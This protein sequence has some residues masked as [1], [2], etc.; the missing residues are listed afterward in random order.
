VEEP[1]NWGFHYDWDFVR[2]SCEIWVRSGY[3]VWP[4]PGGFVDQDPQWLE[5]AL[6]Y[7]RLL[8]VQRQAKKLP[9]HVRNALAEMDNGNET[10]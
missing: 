1:W 5:D 4:Y 8:N 9:M 10:L 3:Q 6:L 7:L 2:L